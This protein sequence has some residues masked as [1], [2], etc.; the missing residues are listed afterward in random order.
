MTEKTIFIAGIFLAVFVFVHSWYYSIK[1]K[2]TRKCYRLAQW[3]VGFLVAGLVA[4]WVL[5]QAG[6]LREV[7]LEIPRNKYV[8][9]LWISG[10]WMLM[11][12]NN[13]TRYYWTMYN[14]REKS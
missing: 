6:F 13:V 14:L 7:L 11:G 3:G 10:I 9:M 5:T 1:G 2:M 4:F 8:I 12:L